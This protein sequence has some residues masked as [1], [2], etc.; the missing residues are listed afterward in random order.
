MQPNG[1]FTLIELAILLAL[2]AI[3]T[4]LAIPAFDTVL[5][6]NRLSTQANDFVAAINFARSEAIR[7]GER[8]TLCRRS[9]SSCDLSPCATCSWAAGWIV[10]V[11]RN[12]PAGWTTPGTP[13]AAEVL[14][15]Y[16]QPIVNSRLETDDT[17][18]GY[19]SFNPLGEPQDSTGLTTVL[20]ELFDGRGKP[21][22]RQIIINAAGRVIASRAQ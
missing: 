6:D 15:R 12:G 17:A 19:I 16:E 7:R 2:T 5:K 20:F 10:A 3:L 14:R 22:G 4:A 11:D 1:G 21:A 8:V 18:S 9:G 13:S